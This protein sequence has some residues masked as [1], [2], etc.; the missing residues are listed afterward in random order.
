MINLALA[1]AGALVMGGWLALL[2]ER[3]RKARDV[4]TQV[5]SDAEDVV[6]AGGD[7]VG[8]FVRKVAGE[9]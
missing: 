7:N 9:R 2:L 6:T 1:A 4:Q 8:Q 3:R 5:V